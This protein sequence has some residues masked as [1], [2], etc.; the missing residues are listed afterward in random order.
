MQEKPA[1]TTI[2][3]EYPFPYEETAEKGNIP[4]YPVFTDDNMAIY[5]RYVADVQDFDNFV[6]LG[7]LAEFRYYNMD[8]VV[9]AALAKYSEL[10]Q[11]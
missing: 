1:K 2:A 9:A 11:K 5:R 6:L 3:V 8:S 10:N 7:R 4:Y